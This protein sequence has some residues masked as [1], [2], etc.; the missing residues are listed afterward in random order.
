VLS[1]KL[2]VFVTSYQL[3][4]E[5][6]FSGN[7]KPERERKREKERKCLLMDLMNKGKERVNIVSS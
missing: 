4:F 3:I 1:S 6:I 7:G 2:L 5:L